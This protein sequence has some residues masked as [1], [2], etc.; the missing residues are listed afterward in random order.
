MYKGS[1]FV[2]WLK[3]TVDCERSPKM[4]KNFSAYGLRKTTIN[5]KSKIIPKIVLIRL[6]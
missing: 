6:N 1:D 4:E 5:Q 2:A 3:K